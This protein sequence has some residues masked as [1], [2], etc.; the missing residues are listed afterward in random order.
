MYSYTQEVSNQLNGLLEKNYDAQKGY[1]TASENAESSTLSHLFERKA[2]ERK[3]FSESLKVEIKFFGKNPIETGS[4]V[5]S[6]HRVWMNT[7]VFLS[8]DSDEAMLEEAIRGEKATVKEYNEVLNS[9]EPLPKSTLKILKDQRN[10]I[11]NDAVLISRL[12]N[13]K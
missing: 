2:N 7:K 10:S 1:L 3:N 11:I 8:P 9:K 12:E 13:R 4:I 5:G 6:A